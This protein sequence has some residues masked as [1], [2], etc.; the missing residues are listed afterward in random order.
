MALAYPWTGCCAPVV[1][2]LWNLAVPGAFMCLSAPYLMVTTINQA[3]L[4][5]FRFQDASIA[6]RFHMMR[7]KHP[8]KFNSR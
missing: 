3:F 6:H 4:A 1:W 5:F 7:E 8:E 2:S